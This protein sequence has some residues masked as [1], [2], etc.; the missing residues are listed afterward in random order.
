MAGI[1]VPEAQKQIGAGA[2]AGTRPAEEGDGLA[3]Q[4]GEVDAVKHGAA[5]A[6]V[7]E[8]DMREADIIVGRSG[9][10]AA[11]GDLRRLA[12]DRQDAGG[13]GPQLADLARSLR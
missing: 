10:G 7:A 6:A 12:K 9:G 4:D 13:A 11:I 3:R 8:A 5:I 1:A 2:L